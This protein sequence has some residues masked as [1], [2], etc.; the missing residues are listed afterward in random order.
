MVLGSSNRNDDT[1]KDI[2]VLLPENLLSTYGAGQEPS[3][4]GRRVPGYGRLPQETTPETFLAG[5]HESLSPTTR[6]DDDQT[7]HSRLGTRDDARPYPGWR[8]LRDTDELIP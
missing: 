7:L 8:G 2:I 3:G 6:A 1:F 4:S 5:V